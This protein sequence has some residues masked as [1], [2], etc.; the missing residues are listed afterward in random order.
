VA[1]VVIM[2]VIDLGQFY[3]MAPTCETRPDHNTGSDQ[4]A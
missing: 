1:Y 4:S 2:I 3:P